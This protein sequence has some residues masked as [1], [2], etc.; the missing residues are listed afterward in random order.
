[1]IL[2]FFTRKR[3]KR[4]VSTTL[5]KQWAMELT[6]IPEWLFQ[7]S[8][9]SVGDLGGTISLILPER[10][11]YKDR[12]IA[13]WMDLIANLKDKTDGQKKAFVLSSWAHLPQL[14]RFIF[15]DLLGGSFRVGVSSKTLVNA[16][17]RYYQ[18]DAS[19][20]AHS[21]MGNW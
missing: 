6:G 16:I 10:P 15:N 12:D 4:N 18:L 5:M 9:A 7:E 14:E 20:V 21:I 19:A 2:A 1:W 11:A 8:Y 17:A 3:P 13:D